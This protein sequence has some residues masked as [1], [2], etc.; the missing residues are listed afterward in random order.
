MDR[1][2][3][4]GASVSVHPDNWPTF[5]SRAA[6]VTRAPCTC[7]RLNFPHR[8]NRKCEELAADLADKNL[9]EDWIDYDRE[10]NDAFTARE[11]QG[12]NDD[13]IRA[14]R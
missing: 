13:T 1:R 6:P 10:Q 3:K 12:I 5:V 2:D 11:A 9:N 14:R 8:L 4:S 7:G